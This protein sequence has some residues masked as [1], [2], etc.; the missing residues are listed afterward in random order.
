V[1]QEN[2]LFYS[3]PR[4]IFLYVEV[5]GLQ[6]MMLPDGMSTDG[7]DGMAKVLPSTNF[8]RGAQRVV[9]YQ[10]FKQSVPLALP[11]PSSYSQTTT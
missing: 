7:D 5:F 9:D 4:D 2:V 11:L 1:A 6:K 10:F 3:Y 8:T